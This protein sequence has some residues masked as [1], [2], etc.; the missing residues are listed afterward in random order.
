MSNVITLASVQETAD[1]KFG[2]LVID[3]GDEK[4]ELVNALRL[5]KEKRAELSA[6]LSPEEEGTDVED[7]LVP[8]IRLVAKTPKQAD[9]LLDAVDGDMAVLSEIVNSYT[10]GTQAGEASS[11]ES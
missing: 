10:K 2:A 3:L 1:Q 7:M 6:V 11:S 5:S 9:A 8:M 4:V